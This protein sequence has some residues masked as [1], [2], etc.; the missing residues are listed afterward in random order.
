MMLDL[1]ATRIAVVVA[2]KFLLV[3]THSAEAC[4]D[5]FHELIIGLVRRGAMRGPL[6]R[7]LPVTGTAAVL[8]LQQVTRDALEECGGRIDLY[9]LLGD[10]PCQTVQRLIGK[11]MG[12]RYAIE[13][14][15]PNGALVQAPV[16]LGGFMLV[17]VQR[18]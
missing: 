14:E 9:P 13:R 16:F 18:Q 2:K 11:S 12:V 3:R 5:A 1:V 10:T 4:L 17:R 7:C 15:Q 6:F 8:F